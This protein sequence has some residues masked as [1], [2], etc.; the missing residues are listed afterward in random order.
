MKR[1]LLLTLLVVGCYREPDGLP[2]TGDKTTSTSCNLDN[3]ITVT[4]D[5]PVYCAAI[6]ANIDMAHQAIVA[7]GWTTEEEFQ[8][9]TAK[10]QITVQTT[11]RCL[12]EDSGHACTY[13]Y[14]VMD[15]A[16]FNWTPTQITENENGT[17]IAHEFLH[18]LCAWN[19]IPSSDHQG[20]DQNGYMEFGREMADKAFHITP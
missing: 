15:G 4:A 17:Q 5:G 2:W 18:V 12:A 7:K 9:M 8:L 3:G 14:T 11:T 6:Q 16:S 20:W 19:N 1:A 13:E 10:T